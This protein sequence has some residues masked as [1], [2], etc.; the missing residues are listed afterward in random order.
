[1]HRTPDCLTEDGFAQAAIEIAVFVEAMKAELGAETGSLIEAIR[2]G[3]DH[4]LRDE[5]I[6]LL[7]DAFTNESDVLA[8]FTANGSF[9]EYPVEIKGIDPLCFVWAPEFDKVGPF[10]SVKAAEAYLLREWTDSLLCLASGSHSPD[11]FIA[12]FPQGRPP[13]R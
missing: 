2:V 9:G 11:D 4:E 6:G 1:M 10:R 7:W 3:R 5:A 8:T 13:A 12:S